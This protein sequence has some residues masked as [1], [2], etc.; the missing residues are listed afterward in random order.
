MPNCNV[1]KTRI[2]KS[3]GDVCP[4][5]GSPIVQPETEEELPKED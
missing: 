3:S 1:C 4:V 2:R 5:C